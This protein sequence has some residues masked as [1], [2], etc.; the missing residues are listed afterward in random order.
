MKPS[1]LSLILA[2]ALVS[3]ACTRP[4][5]SDGEAVYT[6]QRGDTL[7]GL[8]RRFGASTKKLAER[9]KLSNLNRLHVGTRLIVPAG[10]EA[11]G[12]PRY[13]PPLP[14]GQPLVPCAVK[15]WP[16]SKLTDVEGCDKA[17]CTSGS[18]GAR[19]CTCVPTAQGEQ[20]PDDLIFLEEAGV[21]RPVSHQL[22]LFGDFEAFE[23]L[24]VDLDGT[25][26]TERVVAV[27]TGTSN[28]LGVKSWELHILEQGR[29]QPATLDVY[30]Y[31][32]GTFLRRAEDKG[33]DVLQTAWRE[34]EDPLRGSGLYFVGRR[35][36]YRQGAFHP[37]PGAVR[38]RR[39]L[40]EFRWAEPASGEPEEPSSPL[41]SPARW[42][43]EGWTEGWRM[44]P[45]ASEAPGGQSR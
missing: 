11:E 13:Q 25:G 18:T 22:P 15:P 21:R 44:D 33:C 23:V 17:A 43:S 3:A 14:V 27:H 26:S 29:P 35:L 4:G 34:L 38:V 28:G 42:L 39:Y 45:L 30:E 31:G 20:E 32:Q 10:L 5:D 41:G 9:N 40:R 24:E 2:C 12:L 8:G 19:V 37:M 6:V 36:E 16:P 7:S 1:R